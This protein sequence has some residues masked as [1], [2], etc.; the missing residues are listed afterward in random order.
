[1]SLKE[2]RPNRAFSLLYLATHELEASLRSATAFAMLGSFLSMFMVDLTLLITSSVSFTYSSSDSAADGYTGRSSGVRTML[3]MDDANSRRP[4]C[5]VGVEVAPVVVVAAVVAMDLGR[6]RA[7]GF[8]L[9]VGVSRD[10]DAIF[11]L[12]CGGDQEE[13][14]KRRGEREIRGEG[15]L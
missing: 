10:G 3:A 9:D 13:W 15:S 4:D 8:E 2:A 5:R 11:L 1:M 14:L 6:R 7:I 12:L